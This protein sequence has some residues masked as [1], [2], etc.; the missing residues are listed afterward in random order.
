MTTMPLLLA[1]IEGQTLLTPEKIFMGQR[2]LA[3]FPPN[4]A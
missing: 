4:S 3:C 1:E 2:L